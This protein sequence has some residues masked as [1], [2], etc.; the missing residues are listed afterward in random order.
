MSEPTSLEAPARLVRILVVEDEAPL[1]ATLV[2]SLRFEGF[3]CDGAKDG[4]EALAA[5]AEQLPDVIVTD[6]RMPVMGGV[7]L[8]EALREN[9]DT[10]LIPVIMLTA[11]PDRPTHRR[12][13]ELGADDYITK[14]FEIPELLGAIAAQLR[15]RRWRLDSEAAEDGQDIVE[16]A[17]WRYDVERRLLTATDGS[18]LERQLT[19]SE[20]RLLNAFLEQPGRSIERQSLLD[21]MGRPAASPL[22]RSVDVFVNHL[23]QKI[24]PDVRNPV[25]L[26]TVRSVGYVLDLPR[27]RVR[28]YAADRSRG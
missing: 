8:V 23:R 6:I 17:H 18:G 13:M 14:P 15:R 11:V 16:F 28:R 24:E 4:R 22:D 7:E 20:A 27:D 5:V 26:R 12:S 2:R 21:R 25:L 10:R 19:Y 9:P 3:E 1:R